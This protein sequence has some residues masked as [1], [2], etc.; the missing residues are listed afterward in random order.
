MKRCSKCEKEKDISEF[1]ANI[2]NGS[3]DGLH[4]WCKSCFRKDANKRYFLRRKNSEEIRRIRKYANDWRSKNLER[5]NRN[6]KRSYQKTRLE[7]LT[8]Y[9]GNPPKCSCCGEK[10]LEFLSFDHINGNGSKHRRKE[11]Y[12]NL[13]KWLRVNN[14]P[15]G[16]QVLCHNCN[17]AKGHY[18]CCP[19]TK[20][21]V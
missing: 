16:Y 5:S 3:K 17:F 12:V 14:Y 11:K 7:T 1:H 2:N 4:S 6:A 9:G 8:H 18:G 15:N 19:H 21:I 10:R 13:M 20:E